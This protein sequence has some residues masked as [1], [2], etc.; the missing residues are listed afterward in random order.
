MD[1]NSQIDSGS[2]ALG[3][4]S[5]V[6]RRRHSR[7]YVSS[8][9]LAAAADCGAIL[10]TDYRFD[11]YSPLAFVHGSGARRYLAGTRRDFAAAFGLV[12]GTA[13]AV[14]VDARLTFGAVAGLTFGAGVGFAAGDLRVL[15]AAP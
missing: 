4:R 14:I 12:F 1:C 6:A 7:N 15:T 11:C 8:S 2:L 3:W 9:R 10:T 13:L 5:F